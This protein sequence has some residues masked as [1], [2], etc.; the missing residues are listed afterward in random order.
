MRE[1]LKTANPLS[2]KVNCVNEDR[3]EG[4]IYLPKYEL[5]AYDEST[6]TPS[7][8]YLVGNINHI[9]IPICIDT[10]A[11]RSLLSLETW[12]K[13]NENDQLEL[14]K[15]KERDLRQSMARV[16]LATDIGN[17]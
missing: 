11:G 8:S 1:D 17:R 4:N 6:K 14:K 15:N 5:N 2:E 10:G 3:W 12:E 9:S 16:L 13:I 7:L